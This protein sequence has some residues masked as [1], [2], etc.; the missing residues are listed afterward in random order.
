MG[1][2]NKKN[3]GWGDVED[4]TDLLQEDPE[5][6]DAAAPV[7]AEPTPEPTPKGKQGGKGKARQPEPKAEPEPEPE[8]EP[9]A[10]PAA[11]PK[12]GFVEKDTSKM[13]KKQLKEYKMAKK[14]ASQLAIARKAQAEEDARRA[15]EE[16]AERQY[17]EEMQKAAEEAAKAEAERKAAAAAARPKVSNKEKKERARI[18]AARARLQAMG[19]ALP[20]H[21]LTPEEKEQRER[22]RAEGKVPA[23]TDGLVIRAPVPV[24][25]A[26]K[27]GDD[28][29]EAEGDDDGSSVSSESEEEEEEET[30]QREEAEKRAASRFAGVLEERLAEDAKLAEVR[31]ALAAIDQEEEES[32]GG[33]DDVNAIEDEDAPTTYKNLARTAAEIF[34]ENARSPSPVPVTADDDDS[35]PPDDWDASSDDEDSADAE[36]AAVAQREARLAAQRAAAD[37]AETAKQ[38]ALEARRKAAVETAQ[39]RSDRL[40]RRRQLEAKVRARTAELTAEVEAAKTAASFGAAEREAALEQGGG[41]GDKELRSPI[42]CVLGHVD[43]GKTKLLDRI[44]RSNVQGG[45]AGGITQQIGA[46]YFPF[47]TLKEQT[48][49]LATA[50]KKLDKLR[51]KIPGLLV[52]DTPGHESFTNLRSRG[53]SLCDIAILVVDLMHGL[54]PQ[55]IESI[56]LLKKGKTPFVVALNKVDRCYGWKATEGRG[57]RDSLKDQ[58]KATVSEFEDRVRNVV[59]QFAEQGFNSY[60]YWKNPDVRKNIALVPTSAHTGEG[61]PD[62]LMVLI[63]LTQKLM[64]GRVA[65][66][67]KLQATVLEVKQVD[68]FGTTVD[69]V[70]VNG[71]LREGDTIVLC[72]INGPIV[73]TI[74][75]LL[76]PH[77]GKEIRVKGQYLHHKALRGAVGVKIA[78]HELEHAI[79]GS[80]LLVVGP[81]DDVEVLKKLVARDMDSIMSRITKQDRGVHVQASTLGSMEALLSFLADS[82]I[83]VASVGIGP[84]HRRDILKPAAMLEKT[85]EYAVILAFDVSIDKEARN[86]ANKVGVKIF[87]ADI[88]YHLFDQWTA[89][90]KEFRDKVKAGA[91]IDAVWPCVLKVIPEFVF[92][93]KN[94]IVVGCNVEDG[95]LRLGTPICVPSRDMVT[96]GRVTSIERDHNP[97]A[98]AKAGD[99]VAVKI[100][101]TKA[102]EMSVCYGR[103]FDANNALQSHISRK[104][105]EALQKHFRSEVTKED[106][107]LLAKMKKLQGVM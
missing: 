42:C 86:E 50:G 98:E 5:V 63:Q 15:A 85:P 76:T 92:N 52:I 60:V 25:S 51:I 95:T 39:R 87:T 69:A 94:P 102:D 107:K 17:Q 59:G 77:P 80:Q 101:P 67:E 34:A 14:L 31:K 106:V 78:A 37:D 84:V 23:E 30:M 22:D 19:I 2:K 70:L 104:S 57:V 48:T 49:R 105:I 29:G 74:R 71:I 7:E 4:Y 83:P 88:I 54:E 1:K 64:E 89:Y 90:I 20:D 43:T 36:A 28:E 58:S 12:S 35:E 10:K 8:P 91:R 96:L 38:V 26:K 41:G 65:Y 99:Q 40:V 68:G 55:T 3:D 11:A 100:E 61:I 9:E 6:A 82:D 16:E 24:R 18:A 45:E 81:D 93:Q 53:S 75:A 72:G 97:V 32:E 56:N 47:E 103:H 21:L 13:T 33:E 79:A 46:T 27:G 44:R 66:S 73:T 62:L